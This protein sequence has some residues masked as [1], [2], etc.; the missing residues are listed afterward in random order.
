VF[1]RYFKQ[2]SNCVKNILLLFALYFNEGPTS[3]NRYSALSFN[4]AI[5]LNPVNLHYTDS[6]ILKLDKKK[7][8][9]CWESNEQFGFAKRLK[10]RLKSSPDML[11][12][13]Y[14]PL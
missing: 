14:W 4:H 10:W 7:K 12:V 6:I 2:G 5:A 9:A 13:N 1:A 3:P 8:T 11:Y